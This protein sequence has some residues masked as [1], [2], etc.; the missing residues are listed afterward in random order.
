MPRDVVHATYR[1]RMP[2]TLEWVELYSADVE[3]GFE[4]SLQSTYFSLRVL[5]LDEK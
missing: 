4:L 3:V 5:G 2:K 1:E